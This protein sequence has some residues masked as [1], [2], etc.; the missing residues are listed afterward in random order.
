MSLK[1]ITAR[2]EA[3]AEQNALLQARQL[4]LRATLAGFMADRMFA[5]RENLVTDRLER[6]ERHC[7]GRMQAAIDQVKASGGSIATDLD[8][9]KVLREIEASGIQWD[10]RLSN[11]R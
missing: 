6:E 2:V 10:A 9:Q 1:T 3:V 11:T 5:G 4:V 8:V 7:A